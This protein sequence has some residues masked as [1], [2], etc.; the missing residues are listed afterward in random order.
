MGTHREVFYLSGK[1]VNFIKK[2]EKISSLGDQTR[3]AFMKKLFIIFLLTILS[4]R[5]FAQDTLSLKVE[6]R[7]TLEL[8]ILGLLALEAFLDYNYFTSNKRS[9]DIMVGYRYSYKNTVTKIAFFSFDDPFWLYHQISL[10]FGIAHYY[11]EGF[12]YTPMA[13]CNYSFFNHR[14]FKSYEDYEG[15][16]ADEDYIISRNRIAI[17]GLIKAGYAYN[18]GKFRFNMYV[19]AGFR[20]IF[21]NE[22]IHEKLDWMKKLIPA[23]YPIKNHSFNWAPTIHMGLLIGLNFK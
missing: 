11:S 14:Y 23:D 9:I 17:G 7:H 22:T 5:L 6:K 18:L 4:T 10:R 21:K 16:G 20:G 12:Y 19:G 13:I 15:E 2:S 8:N 3:I 1:A